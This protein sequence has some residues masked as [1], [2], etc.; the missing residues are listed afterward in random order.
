MGL[1]KNETGR[2]SRPWLADVMNEG[3]SVATTDPVQPGVIDPVQDHDA[4]LLTQA[5]RDVKTTTEAAVN[6]D[7]DDF[8]GLDTSRGN[9]GEIEAK[10]DN[11]A[12][13]GASPNAHVSV[14]DLDSES[15]AEEIDTDTDEDKATKYLNQATAAERLAQLDD[16]LVYLNTDSTKMAGTVKHLENSLEYSHK[17]IADLKKENASLKLRLGNIET[18][19]K[20]T[21]FQIKDVADKLDKLDSFSKKKNLIFEGIAEK[22]GKREETE[23]VISSLFDQLQ[24]NKGVE[25]EACYRVGSY[26]K[27][28]PRPILV[29]FNRQTDRDLIYSR[30]MD[31]KRTIDHQ[32]VWINEDVSPASRRKREIIRLITREAH[33]Q[34]IDCKSGKYALRINNVRYDESNLDDLPPPLHPIN[35]KQVQIDK[36]TL[37]YQSE[38]APFS[39]FFASP[40]TIGK[41]RFFCAEQ[42]F[43]FLKAKTL[44]KPL[45][46]TRIYLSRDVRFI[47][48]CGQ[49]LGTSDDWEA[50]KYDYMYLCLKRKYEQNPA[51]KA[52]LLD[53]GNMELVE[54][55]PDRHWGCGAT[56][57]SNVL[58]RH[59]WVGLNKHGAI[60]MTIRE[61]FRQT[62]LKKI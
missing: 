44:N 51:L 31:L 4:G 13:R 40:I 11:N 30:R 29:S 36:D 38:H 1:I 20:R 50:R 58:K 19:D 48:Q 45:A 53:S 14:S 5:L 23:K 47:K 7:P 41:H 3:P 42:A 12:G 17:E 25:F 32:K 35:L 39:N 56:L 34:G 9:M 6:D 55:T 62:S 28:R 21:Q 49:D 24:V 8:E 59:T 46:A 2:A 37:A 43:Q 54:A 15:A 52:L 57:S 26:N 10:D 16:L 18:E 60:L 22:E 61:E 33:E 27:M